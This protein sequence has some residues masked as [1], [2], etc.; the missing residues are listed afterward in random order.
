MRCLKRE[1]IRLFCCAALVLFCFFLTAERE[2]RVMLPLSG[3]KVVLDAGHGGWDPGKTGTSGFSHEKDLN[4]FVTECLAEY[5]ELAGVE[6]V[7]TRNADEALAEGKG[8]DLAERK[9]IAE[10]S[11]AELLIS[12]HQ[13]AFPSRRVWGAQVFYHKG[14]AE[15]KRLADCVQESLK[16]VL[17]D[18]NKRTAK[19]NESYYMLRTVKMPAIIIECGF[20]S[21]REE[22][23]LLNDARYREK[24]AWAVLAGVQAY[25]EGNQH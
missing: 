25:F 4:L 2:K 13:N 15:G 16:T 6:T 8:K 14:S 5:L 3:H 24:L 21:N 18:G 23:K 20:L 22:E 10:E 7:C 17:S 9:R 11:G 19:E 1:K 12:I